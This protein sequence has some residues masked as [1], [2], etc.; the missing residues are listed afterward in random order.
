MLRKQIVIVRKAQMKL[1]NGKFKSRKHKMKLRNR[2]WENNIL[3]IRLI[4]NKLYLYVHIYIYYYKS[5]RIHMI[6]WATGMFF[7]IC[8][9]LPRLNFVNMADVSANFPK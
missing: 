5:M 2:N 4:R 6:W 7:S 9:N 3:I 8:H 1:E